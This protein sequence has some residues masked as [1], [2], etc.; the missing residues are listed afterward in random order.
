VGIKR[1]GI[2]WSAATTA[3]QHPAVLTH[4]QQQRPDPV[5]PP[6]AAAAVVA[7][8]GGRPLALHALAVEGAGGAPRL[9]STRLVIESR[10]VSKPLALAGQLRPR[11][12]RE[13]AVLTHR[14]IAVA[15]RPL[16][17]LLLLAVAPMGGQPH[18]PC[19]GDARRG[20]QPG[21]T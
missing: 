12:P 11:R 7:Q 16:L 14:Q 17:L 15:Q 3:T 8:L 13:L 1:A 5:L 4:L 2:R 9:Q 10:W 6:P 19:G 21:E 20:E 18:G